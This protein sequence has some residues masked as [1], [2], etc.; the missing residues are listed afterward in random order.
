MC[1]GEHALSLPIFQVSFRARFLRCMDY[2]GRFVAAVALF[3]LPD[4]SSDNDDDDDDD[5]DASTP[6]PVRCLRARKPQPLSLRMQM[7]G[8]SESSLS[9]L[10]VMSLSGMLPRFPS[11][12]AFAYCCQCPSFLFTANPM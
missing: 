5:D 9:R 12:T 8:N 1:F 2:R 7:S 6:Q 4:S 11:T 10:I 3:E